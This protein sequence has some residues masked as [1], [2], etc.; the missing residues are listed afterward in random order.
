MSMQ[1]YEAALVY[2]QPLRCSILWTSLQDTRDS[3]FLRGDRLVSLYYI[4]YEETAYEDQHI[5]RNVQESG[6][7][8][9][10]YG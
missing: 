10:H 5:L 4:L 6:T 3:Q 9:C 8:D 1:H 2:P 7:Y